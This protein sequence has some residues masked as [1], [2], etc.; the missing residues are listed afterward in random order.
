MTNVSVYD[1]EAEKL[2]QLAEEH[3]TSVAEVVE[4][5]F[6]AIN[7]AQINIGDYV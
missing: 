5:I 6:D 7:D 3:D 2:E 1:V 4:A